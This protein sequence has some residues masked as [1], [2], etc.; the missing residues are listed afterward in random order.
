M[1][2]HADFEKNIKGTMTSV[3]EDA[4]T[5]R[6]KEIAGVVSQAAYAR[7]STSD[8][9]KQYELFNTVSFLN[10]QIWPML[11]LSFVNAYHVERQEL[12][13]QDQWELYSLPFGT[14]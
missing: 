12:S 2:Y 9:C 8:G 5:K 11:I 10:T 13:Y 3:A 6:V 1:A 14:C 4:E 7:T